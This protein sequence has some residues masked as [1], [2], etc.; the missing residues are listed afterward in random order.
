MLVSI[1]SC[2]LLPSGSIVCLLR[3]VIV[4]PMNSKLSAMLVRIMIINNEY[5]ESSTV[6]LLGLWQ[7]FV[8]FLLLS[9]LFALAS[10]NGRFSLLY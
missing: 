5:D 9:C 3:S 10:Y 6:V 2:L 8:Y 1:H 4:T 7:P